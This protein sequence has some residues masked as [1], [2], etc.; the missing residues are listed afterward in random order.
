[1]ITVKDLTKKYGDKAALDRLSFTI[2]KGGVHGIL[3]PCG[4][5]KTTLMN[6]ISGCLAPDGGRVTLLDTDVVADPTAAKRRIG[7][8][9]QKLPLYEN[10][11]VVGVVE[12]GIMGHG[13]T[14]FPIE[15]ENTTKQFNGTCTRIKDI[16]KLADG[17]E[18]T[19]I[20]N[21]TTTFTD[22]QN[23]ILI[24]DYTGGI[25]LRN[26]S[27]GDNSTAK[28][29]PGMQISN[30]K[31]K[32]YDA[33]GDVMPSI[34]ITEEDI[35]NVTISNTEQP[36]DYY[37][38]DVNVINHFYSKYFVGKAL[39]LRQPTILEKD[40]AYTFVFS[41]YDS[42]GNETRVVMP[43]LF[44]GTIDLTAKIFIGYARKFNGVLT[45]VVV[46]TEEPDQSVDVDQFE[47]LNVVYLA[48]NTIIACNTT[49]IEVY[50]ING[51]QLA[52]ANAEQLDVTTLHRGIYIVRTHHLDG[53]TQITKIIK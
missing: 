28:I 5:G 45:F 12:Y 46:S 52:K 33:S 47:N 14:I 29:Q 23:G 37:S 3:G 25:L 30:I 39:M 51:R 19:Y 1:M 6:I 26:P 7:Y 18:F 21:A 38:T 9:P 40:G 4:A 49:S 20:G 27:L 17:T 43:A 53:T 11:T 44:K 10:M 36:I 24:E 8:L 22:Y 15:V 48:H 34:L 32:Y 31:G 42:S 41:Y 2:E 13:L 16:K 35:N 50:D